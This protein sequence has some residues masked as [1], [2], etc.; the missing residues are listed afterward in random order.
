[1]ASALYPKAVEQA[2][3]TLIGST[4]TPA[5]TLS[6]CVVDTGTYTYSAAHE[7]ES[8]LSGVVGSPVALSTVTNTLGVIDADNPEF[9]GL[10]GDSIEA[11]VIFLDTGTPATSRLI[12]YLDGLTYTPN[13][14]DLTL[15]VDA[16]GLFKL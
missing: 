7:F 16:Q 2:A 14:A 11:V 5:G 13:G 12:A 9:L 6:V 15:T 8:D 4:V 3:A 10:N 1:M